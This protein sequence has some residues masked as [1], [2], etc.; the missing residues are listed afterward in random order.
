MAGEPAR[1]IDR[2]ELRFERLGVTFRFTFAFHAREV[3]FERDLGD[4]FERVFPE[5]FSFHI[6]RHDPAELF[7]QL[8]DLM[9][10]PR[11]LSPRA[12]RRDARELVMR[13]LANVPRYLANM[14]ERLAKEGRLDA[15]AGLRFA[16]DIALLSQILLRFIDTGDLDEQRPVRVGGFLLRKLVFRSLLALMNGR[17]GDDYLARYVRGEVDPIDRGDDPSESGFFHAL[18]APEQSESADRMIVRMAERAFYLWLEAVCLDEEN[19][20]FEK[21]DSPFASREHEVAW[22]IAADGPGGAVGSTGSGERAD[23]QRAQDLVP[24]LRRPSRDCF[25]LLKKLEVWFLRQYDVHHAA[26][27]IEHTAALRNN[28]YDGGRTLS[29]HGPANYVLALGVLAA[30]FVV[31]IFAYDRAPLFFDLVCAAEVALINAVAAWFFFYSF[32]W[33]RD[34]TFFHTSVPRIMAGI[35]VGY[36]PVF[37]IDEVWDLASRPAYALMALSTLLGL[38]TLLYLFIEVQQRLGDPTVA[39]AR[40]RGIFVLGL[41]EAFGLGIVMT[42]LVGPFM[43]ARN[44]SIGEEVPLETLR[45]GLEPMLGQLPPVLGIEPL[46]LFPS[47]LLIMTPLSFFI[48]I[49]LQLMWEELPITEPL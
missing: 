16:Q 23:L 48:G 3:R 15:A 39:F 4:G 35:I 2:L 42:N 31:A 49:F 13:L 30:P 1:G 19:Q 44:W 37:L 6:E 34:L 9:R 45:T 46:Y 14:S 29:R 8:D 10:K 7:L 38:V 28:D 40:A 27:M 21:E 17:V 25:R 36:L 12:H 24:F 26:S 5:T 11:L 33:K 41:L 32:C 20:A 43:V 22:A 47:A 18:E